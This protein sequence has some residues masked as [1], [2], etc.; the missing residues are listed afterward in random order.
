MSETKT[1]WVEEVLATIEADAKAC[2]ADAKRH[3]EKGD[4]L[5]SY[6]MATQAMAH[7]LDIARFRMAKPPTPQVSVS[8]E[9]DNYLR[10]NY[11]DVQ[12]Q[13]MK[14]WIAALENNPEV[15]QEEVYNRVKK[16]LLDWTTIYVRGANLASVIL[17][18]D[19][20]KK[21]QIPQVSGDLKELLQKIDVAA[22]YLSVRQIDEIKGLL[23]SFLT[24]RD[25]E[26]RRV[27]ELVEGGLRHDHTRSCGYFNPKANYICNCGRD[28]KV[29]ESLTVITTFL[30][31]LSGGGE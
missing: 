17:E 4:E 3:K 6:L 14:K 10:Q 11:Y 26:T 16:R 2:E 30:S 9:M 19:E 31:K 15:S 24:H 22:N 29:K 8:A 13:E 25:A 27:L 18:R 1:D 7:Q 28:E 12:E 23:Q 5:N 21:R 20:L